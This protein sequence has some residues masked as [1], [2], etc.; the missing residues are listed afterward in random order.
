MSIFY[1]ELRLSIWFWINEQYQKLNG[2]SILIK[3][4]TKAEVKTKIQTFITCYT[5]QHCYQG[6]CLILLLRPRPA[7]RCKQQRTPKQ[8][9]LRFLAK[10]QRFWQLCPTPRTPSPPL[11]HGMKRKKIIAKIINSNT[12]KMAPPQP[13]KSIQPSR[14][15][16]IRKRLITEAEIVW[17]ERLKN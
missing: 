6:S 8:K 1:K 16:P 13:P 5:N 15:R 4:V 17:V 12:S 3:K 11:K 14:V 10:S 9:N 7:P 2:L